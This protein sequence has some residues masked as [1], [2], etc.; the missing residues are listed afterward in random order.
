LHS[1]I[2]DLRTLST[3][4]GRL[5]QPAACSRSI[6]GIKFAMLGF[7]DRKDVLTVASSRD[8]FVQLNLDRRRP[9]TSA[10]IV[11]RRWAEPLPDLASSPIAVFAIVARGVTVHVY[12][13]LELVVGW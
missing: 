13:N 8:S 10:M 11:A 6:D 4:S 12:R 9:A 7:Y 3:A 2:V 5:S 1:A